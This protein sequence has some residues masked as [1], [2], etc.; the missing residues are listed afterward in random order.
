[1]AASAWLT[2]DIDLKVVFETP[3]DQMWESAIRRLGTDPGSL[4]LGSGVH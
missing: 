4:Q 1:V 3:A 2:T